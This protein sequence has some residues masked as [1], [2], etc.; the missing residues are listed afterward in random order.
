MRARTKLAPMNPA[1]PVTR[2]RLLMPKSSLRYD[3]RL[4]PFTATFHLATQKLL[5]EP[6]ACPP[7]PSPTK[8]AFL[9]PALESQSPDRST[10]CCAPLAAHK[11]PSPCTAPRQPAKA[12]GTRGQTP[13][14]SRASAYSLRSADVPSI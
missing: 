14:V 6:A 4:H 12:P 8:S 10:K 2:R 11:S 7:S 5:L 13:Q 1:P 3:N 9:R